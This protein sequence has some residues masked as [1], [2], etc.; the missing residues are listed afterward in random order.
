MRLPFFRVHRPLTW[1]DRIRR[2][3]RHGFTEQ[4]RKLAVQFTTCAVGEHIGHYSAEP[5]GD[6]PY[7]PQLF[8]LGVDFLHAIENHD[9]IAAQMVYEVI[10]DYF[11]ATPT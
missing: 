3:R 2:A 6:I 9:P 11:K 5:T 1:A 10:Q 8:H 7:D 4:D